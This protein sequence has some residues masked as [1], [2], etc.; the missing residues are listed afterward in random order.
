MSLVIHYFAY[1]S[2]LLEERLR[3]HVPSA[4]LVAAGTV[5]GWHRVF[6]L[7]SRDGSAK[8]D[9]VPAKDPGAVVEGALYEL[10]PD[11][12][13]ALDAWEGLGS[14]YRLDEV[15][16]VTG[17]GSVTSFTYCGSPSHQAAGLRPYDWYLAS[18]IAG[19]TRLSLTGETLAALRAVPA[20]RDRDA[21]RAERN[22]SLIPAALRTVDLGA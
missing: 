6:H 5:T 16:V 19:A 2:N 1:G 14:M 22:W 3:L 18:V 8:A 9:L 7:R 17:N 13:P 10:D 4:R 20:W 21:V 12:R 15:E 11:E